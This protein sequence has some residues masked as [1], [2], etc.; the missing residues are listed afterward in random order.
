MD[1]VNVPKLLLLTTGAG[2]LLGA[3][4]KNFQVLLSQAYRPLF[5]ISCWFV[6]SFL[7]VAA[8][9][10]QSLFRSIVGAWG[11]NNGLFHYISLLI[12]FL[13]LATQKSKLP[14]INAIK[15]LSFL[16]FGSVVYGFLQILGRDPIKWENQGNKLILTLGNSNFSG[17]FMALTAL[18]SFVY[19][20]KLTK[21]NFIRIFLSTSLLFQIF[22]ILKTDALQGLIIFLFGTGLFLGFIFSFS[23]SKI[24]NR[25]SRFWW[26][27][28]ATF[29]FLGVASVFGVGPLASTISPFLGSLKDRYYH[30]LAAI[31]MLSDHLFIGVGI[32]S[33]GDYY[34][35]NRVQAAIDARGTA[36][37]GTN[38]AH[39]V[40][41]QIGATGGLVLVSAYIALIVFVVHRAIYALRKQD[42]K[43][44]TASL[45]SIWIAFQLQSFVSIDQ[46][47]LSVWGW[48]I[49]GCI[50]A[51]SF[52]HLQPASFELVESKKKGKLQK[53]SS[54]QH[55]YVSLF[56]TIVGL[57]PA[58]IMA[59]VVFNEIMLKNRIIGFVT[60]NTQV[61]ARD[62]AQIL[63]S[64]ARKSKQ[65][66]LRLQAVNYL[67]ALKE[68]D[69]AL[70]LALL[71]NKEFP[72]SFE[73]WDA[74]AR[75]YESL[76][77]GQRAVYPRQQS[78]RLDPLNKELKKLLEVD[79]LKN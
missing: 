66:E 58:M 32:D 34:R 46:I 47:G 78:V 73:S 68:S 62:N 15:T 39:N 36:A 72:G 11:R 14:G 56:V 60:S 2:V 33:F 53:F 45:F 55:S 25:L 35:L 76:G 64:I 40:F 42:D 6:L 51:N 38:N 12:L 50:V 1:P 17:A 26:V 37:T 10:P 57:I 29:V 65:P 75:I 71:N 27:S 3:F 41:F 70:T 49:G 28:F 79:Q 19:L 61:E 63:V 69:A 43:I 31:N 54:R 4:W 77:D 67:L 13:A 22:L 5:L 24:I 23:N 21:N 8:L 16:G 18:A 44:L 30:W 52:H 74:T 20:T 59:P 9:S 7:L 48:V